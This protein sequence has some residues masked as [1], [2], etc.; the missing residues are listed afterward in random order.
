MAL[1]VCKNVENLDQKSFSFKVQ[2]TRDT[3]LV[4]A[5]NIGLLNSKRFNFIDLFETDI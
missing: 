4:L 1:R 2:G 3:F 5:R